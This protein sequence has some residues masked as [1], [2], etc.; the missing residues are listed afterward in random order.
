[1]GKILQMIYELER[2]ARPVV[3]GGDV[4][5]GV[6]ASLLCQ[7]EAAPICI[8]DYFLQWSREDGQMALRDL[9]RWQQR[10]RNFDG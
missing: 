8:G 7:G 5:V 6:V 2:R 3:N 9:R 4:S 10:R 1:M